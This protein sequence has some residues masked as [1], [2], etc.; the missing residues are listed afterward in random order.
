MQ[1]RTALRAVAIA[2]TGLA[3]IGPLDA[4]AD[5]V[6]VEEFYGTGLRATSVVRVSEQISDCGDTDPATNIVAQTSTGTVTYTGFMEGTGEVLNKG[7][8]DNCGGQTHTSYRLIDTFESLMVAGRT[9]GAAVEIVGRLNSPAP[10]VTLN[11][12]RIRI[13]CGTG[14]LK[15]VHAEGTVV[16]TATATGAFSAFQLWAH[17]RH[18]HDVGFDFLCR[19]LDQ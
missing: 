15:G 1:T 16:G 19:D 4:S 13:L 3:T 7:V 9:G 6:K 12:S 18:N 17:F 11:E 2:L 5:E 10:G 14:E 8:S